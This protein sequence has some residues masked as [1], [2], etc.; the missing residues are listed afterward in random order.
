MNMEQMQA[1]KAAMAEWLAHPQELGHEPAEIECAGTF[2]LHEMTYY[3]FKYRAEAGGAW[4][5]GICGGYEGDGLEHCG[6]V[7]SEMEEYDP[8]TAEEKAAAMVEMVRTYWMEQ[9]KEIEARKNRAGSFAGFVLMAEAKWDKERLIN[10]LKEEWEIEAVEDNDDKREDSLVFDVGNVIAAVSLMPSPI[11]DGEA[12]ANAAN[13]YMWPEAVDAAKAHKAHIMV[14]IIGKE[15]NLLERGKLFTKIL[16]C[17][18]ALPGAL[19]VYTSGV[20][21]APW[22][23]AKFA[24]I[25]KEGE[26]PIYNWIWIGLYRSEKGF[27]GYTYGMVEFG[28]DEMEV[29]DADADPNDLRDFIYSL[30]DYVLAYDVTLK[31]GETIGFSAEDKHAITYSEGVSLPGMTLKVEY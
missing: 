6:H 7:F 8:A 16:A 18:C 24:N 27:S 25:M 17:C 22:F 13:N 3:L 1:A 9:A 20:V 11:P 29:L 15:E 2:E 14:A 4:L 10:D 21:F 5:L 26:L 12:E 19:G 30:A 31:D 28:K 23:Y